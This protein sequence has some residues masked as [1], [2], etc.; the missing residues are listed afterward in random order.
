MLICIDH[1]STK[2]K[3]DDNNEF[4]I[5]VLVIFCCPNNSTSPML[6]YIWKCTIWILNIAMIL[7]I[8]LL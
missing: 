6:P 4:E 7:E 1:M 5:A 2:V 3:S 8:Y